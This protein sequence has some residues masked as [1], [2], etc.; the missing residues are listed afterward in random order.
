LAIKLNEK[1]ECATL[2]SPAA[3]IGVFKNLRKRIGAVG[4]FK[5]YYTMVKNERDFREALDNLLTMALLMHRTNMGNIQLLD[6]KTGFLKI[7]AQQGFSASFLEYFKE[8]S[9]TDNSACG[10]ALHTGEIVVIEDVTADP[11]YSPHK[12]IAISAGYRSVQST[13]LISRDGN[14]LGILSTHFRTPRKFSEEELK[15]LREYGQ[16]SADIIMN[17]IKA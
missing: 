6:K 11:L 3:S 5:K 15:S 13:P 12:K 9:V 8:V 2:L 17:L 1:T 14:L 10:R 4:M 16:H 7:V